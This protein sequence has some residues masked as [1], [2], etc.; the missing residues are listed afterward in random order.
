MEKFTTESVKDFETVVDYTTVLDNFE[1]PL[2]LLLYLIER[3]KIEIKDVFVSQVTE[4]FLDYMKGL[5]YIDLD[6]ASEYLYIASTIIS[7]KAKRLVPPE[8]EE[9]MDDD[10]DYGEE[11]EQLIQALKD[12]YELLQQGAEKLKDLETVGYY[13]KEPDTDFSEVQI[14]YKDIDLDGMVKALNSML[15]RREAMER[16]KPISRSI[17][18]DKFTVVDKI[19]HIRTIIKEKQEISFEELFSKES[20]VPEVVTTFQALLE[21]LKYQFV[22]VEQDELFSKI[23][24]KNNPN[25]SEEEEIGEIDEYN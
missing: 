11:G 3:A 5:P 14:K 1:G 25:K 19:K 17:P 13:F 9:W 16:K 10:Y 23:T 4:Q 21:L 2:D 12:E 15:L 22:F 6:K 18:K 7:I 24:I 8:N 20:T